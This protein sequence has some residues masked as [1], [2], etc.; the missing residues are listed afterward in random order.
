MLVG[1]SDERVRVRGSGVAAA[2]HW[3][4]ARRQERGSSGLVSDPRGM[5]DRSPL[6][7]RAPQDVNL[8]VRRPQPQPP[9]LAPCVE[10]EPTP[11]CVASLSTPGLYTLLPSRS[12]F[13][14]GAHSRAMFRRAPPPLHYPGLAVA[15]RAL[16]RSARWRAARHGRLPRDRQESRRTTHRLDRRVRKSEVTATTARPVSPIGLW[17]S[18]SME[19]ARIGQPVQDSGR[20][21]EPGNDCSAVGS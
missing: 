14:V 15:G 1:L 10:R 2:V 12:R 19:E 4:G 7:A 6:G 21:V 16:G 20:V 8:P 13:A 5:T 17:T 9:L 3:Q 11:A 18:S